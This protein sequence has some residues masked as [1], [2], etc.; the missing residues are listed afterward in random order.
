MNFL[1]KIKVK[2]M[3]KKVRERKEGECDKRERK[4]KKMG[5]LIQV[6]EKLSGDI[7]NI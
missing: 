4:E 1:E 2:E 3:K 7:L 6:N 5:L